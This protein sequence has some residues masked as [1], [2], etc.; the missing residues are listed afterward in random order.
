MNTDITT[1]DDDKHHR[2][3]LVCPYTVCKRASNKMLQEAFILLQHM[4]TCQNKKYCNK[5]NISYG[6]YF[7]L[8]Y[9]TLVDGL[10]TAALF[11]RFNIHRIQ[12]TAI[13]AVS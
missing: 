1:D 2:T 9:F 8:F 4:W 10:S 6:I 3:L 7:I 13:K 11:S 12:T 5:I